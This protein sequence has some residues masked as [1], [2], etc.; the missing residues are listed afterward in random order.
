[1]L[2]GANHCGIN[3]SDFAEKLKSGRGTGDL[4]GDFIRARNRADCRNGQC[5]VR[6]SEPARSTTP[7]QDEPRALPRAKDV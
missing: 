7:R 2:T 1:M 3:L 6:Q 5:F 4:A